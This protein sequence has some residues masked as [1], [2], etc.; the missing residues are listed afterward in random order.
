[1]SQDIQS[2][3]ESNRLFNSDLAPTAAH[4]DASLGA[5]IDSCALML[6]S[7]DTGLSQSGDACSYA[8]QH[9][10]AHLINSYSH[11]MHSLQSDWAETDNH[12]PCEE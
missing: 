8:A 2:I 6:E 3:V 12:W 11:A 1:M 9:C 7:C 10:S 5:P 4:A